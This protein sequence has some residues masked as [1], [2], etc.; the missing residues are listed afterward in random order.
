LL[1]VSTAV[2]AEAFIRGRLLYAV[3]LVPVLC[4]A[5]V[6]LLLYSLFRTTN[7]RVALF[8]ASIN[9]VGLFFEAIERHILGVNAALAFHAVYCVLIGYLIIRSTLLPRILGVLMAMAGVAWL[10]TSLP[11]LSRTLHEYTQALGFFGEGLLM[12]RLLVLGVKLQK[13]LH[14]ASFV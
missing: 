5:V 13:Q 10:L 6:T 4:F 7:K 12:L 3:G 11:H 2:F 1:S 9:I 8:A 14:N